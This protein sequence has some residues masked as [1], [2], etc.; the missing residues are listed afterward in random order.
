MRENRTRWGARDSSVAIRR[1]G[2]LSRVGELESRA[3]T[4]TRKGL[5]WTALPIIHG[6]Q[7]NEMP[8][9]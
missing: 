6:R 3:V 8:R 7:K 1:T 5:L 4:N 2:F 9:M